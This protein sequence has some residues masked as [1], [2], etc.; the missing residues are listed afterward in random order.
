MDIYFAGSIRGGREDADLYHRICL[1]LQKT[2]NVLTKHVGDLI[3]QEDLTDKEIFSR[4]IL[5]IRKADIVIAECTSP[6][7]G[8]GYELAYAEMHNKPVHIFYKDGGRIS[9]MLKGNPYFIIHPYTNETEIYFE[10]NKI[11]GR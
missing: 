11:L 7:H 8:V 5:W 2:D 4:D 1:Y 10:L 3:V 9:A 6:S